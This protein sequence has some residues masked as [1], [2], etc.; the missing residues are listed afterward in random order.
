MGPPDGCLALRCPPLASLT[1]PPAVTKPSRV[2]INL[3]FSLLVAGTD[4]NT[5]AEE[6]LPSIAR[7]AR[8][9]HT[10]SPA[11][12]APPFPPKHGCKK[13][14]GDGLGVLALPCRPRAGEG[15]R[16]HPVPP[17]WHGAVLPKHAGTTFLLLFSPLLASLGAGLDDRCAT[18]EQEHRWQQS[19]PSHEGLPRPNILVATCPFGSRSQ[20]GSGMRRRRS[21]RVPRRGSVGY[22]SSLPPGTTRPPGRW[23]PLWHSGSRHRLA[24][25]RGLAIAL[26][27]DDTA[28]LLDQFVTDG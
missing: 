24:R 19:Q 18:H 12:A 6:G 27:E 15:T 3:Y 16:W 23:P 28:E 22:P 4:T 1:A 8:Q 10:A 5:L 13:G 7:T 11:P 21:V 26:P 17:S 2:Q 20:P 9:A 25:P 14:R